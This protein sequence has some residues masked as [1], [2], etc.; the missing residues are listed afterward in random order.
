[1]M[2]LIFC[3][4]ANRKYM[5]M[6]RA[7]G[8]WPGARLPTTLYAAHHPLAFADQ[9]WTAYQ[10]ATNKPAHRAAYM[11]ALDAARPYMASVIDWEYPDQLSEVIDWAHEAAQYCERVMFIPKVVKAV[12]RLPD[13]IDSVPVVLGYSIPTTHGGTRC[14]LREFDGRR[15]HLLGGSPR[16]QLQSARMID[17]RAKLVSADG[18]MLHKA[19]GRGTYWTGHNWRNDGARV[20]TTDEAMRRSLINIRQMWINAGF[21]LEEPPLW[22]E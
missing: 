2:R 20:T 1:M 4:G 10:K 9:N 11:A 19:A 3:L 14:G 6:A 8:W 13:T 5:P 7:A 12:N 18:N 22:S 21:H 15:V 17:D 16:A